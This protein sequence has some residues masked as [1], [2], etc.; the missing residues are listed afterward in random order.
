M[1]RIRS[2]R[3]SNLHLEALDA[4]MRINLNG[5][6]DL[7]RFP[8]IK[9][10]KLWVKA[11]HMKTDDPARVKRKKVDFLDDN[12]LEDSFLESNLF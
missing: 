12:E 1:K 5:P 10:A 2:D 11:G 8:A 3:R 4:L 7:E 9:Y 6:N